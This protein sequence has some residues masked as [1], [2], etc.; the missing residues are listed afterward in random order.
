MFRRLALIVA[1]VLAAPATALAQGAC[2]P[3]DAMIASAEAQFDEHL[4]AQGMTLHNRHLIE[5]FV[6]PDG[7]WTML[8]SP[9][10]DVACVLGV[11][12][13]WLAA[14][15]SP[16]SSDLPQAPGK[17]GFRIPPGKRQPVSWP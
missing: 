5:L 14:P 4:T 2:G 13:M 17:T 9:S 16:Q 6:S 10:E 3:R 12:D 11:G 1:I 15:G 7:T 8:V